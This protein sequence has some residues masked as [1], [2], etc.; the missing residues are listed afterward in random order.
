MSSI[1]SNSTYMLISKMSRALLDTLAVMLLSRTLGFQEY[2]FY[3][4]FIVSQQILTAIMSLG[5]PSSTIFY[6]SSEKKK[7]Y[8]ANIYVSLGMISMLTIFIT[9]LF[10]KLFD[11]NFKTDF[12]ATNWPK[13]S[14]IY[15]LSVFVT[16]SENMMIAMNKLKY[17]PIY[18]LVPS[19][20][21]TSGIVFSIIF[22]AN[23]NFVLMIFLI[24]YLLYFILTIVFVHE[25]FDFKE[26]N[27]NRIKEILLFGLPV[28]ISSMIG[29]FSSN[30]AKLVVGNLYDT[31][32]FA[33]FSNGAYE[34]PLLSII[35]SSLFSVIIPQLKSYFDGKKFDEVNRLWNKAGLSMIPII[36]SLASSFIVFSKPIVLFL[37][38]EKYVLSIPYFSLYQINLLF[39]IYSYG[40]FFIAVGKSRLYMINA[41]I[42]MVLNLVLD[43]TLTILIGPMGAII[44][45]LISTFTLVLL[46]RYQISKILN[47]SMLKIYPW[48]EW[49]LSIG[50]SLLVS[51]SCYIAYGFLGT[52]VYLGLIF[53]ILSFGISFLLLSTFVDDQVLKYTLSILKRKTKRRPQ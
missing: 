15:A 24:R 5:I 50:I 20:F 37:F 18:V 7:E 26:L 44:A 33:I 29:M 46:Q 2:G 38:S 22:K 8:L 36:V 1:K 12:F 16:A 11:L 51:A 34:I 10:T 23:L 49:V 25:K 41:A 9:P 21:W 14:I 40:S 32:T 39:R 53:T 31:E 43:I 47:M 13:L 6:L 19:A 48:K 27:K 17:M 3:K 28:G 45:G 52:S 30:I 35:G 4:Q 42:S